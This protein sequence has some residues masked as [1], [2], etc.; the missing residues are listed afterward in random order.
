MI[1]S[2]FSL[3]AATAMAAA[4]TTSCHRGSASSPSIIRDVPEPVELAL[5]YL[6]R[7]VPQWRPHNGC[8]SCHNNGDAARAL[9]T[10]ARLGLSDVEP[11]TATTT[12]WL[13]NPEGWDH[14]GG[15]GEFSDKGLARIQFAASLLAARRAGFVS[16]DAPLVKAAQMVAEYQSESGGWQEENSGIIGSPVT[17][18]PV[19]ATYMARQTLMAVGPQRFASE[20]V[21][22][23]R[24]LRGREVRSV[25][26][27]AAMLLALE[28]ADDPQAR[29][30]RTRSL[31]LIKRG[32]APEG[33][34]GPYLTSATEPFDTALVLLALAPLK[35]SLD[36]RYMVQRGRSYLL[37]SQEADGSWIETTRPAG[38]ESYAQR[39]S[40]AG[41]VTQALLVTARE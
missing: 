25:M 18:G 34:W 24:W 7:E 26:D 23:N 3:L 14:N 13:H 29:A 1:R 27:A 19:L 4:V 38:F 28:G 16:D 5:S 8:Y 36:Y 35:D 22:A 11:Q 10:A 33:G 40:T 39:L 9:Y 37:S 31:D 15:E 2:W 32:Q 30:L 6:R 12:Q 41:W 21:R 17:Y 20:I